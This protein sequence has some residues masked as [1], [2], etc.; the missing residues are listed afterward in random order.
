MMFEFSRLLRL[1]VILK[2]RIHTQ[3]PLAIKIQAFCHRIS[4]VIT[5]LLMMFQ[6]SKLLRKVFIGK[7][8]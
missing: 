5:A 4:F 1:I 6:V 7:F 8:W 2:F 3:F